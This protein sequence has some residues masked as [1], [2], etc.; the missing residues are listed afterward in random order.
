VI[1]RFCLLLSLGFAAAAPVVAEPRDGVERLRAQLI[2][3]GEAEAK[4]ER[5]VGDQRARLLALNAAQAELDARMAKNRGDM[6]KLLGAL[7]LYQRNPPPALVV[8]ARSAKDAVRAAILIRAVTPQLEQRRLA[9][10]AETNLLNKLRRDAAIASAALFESESAAAERRAHTDRL[11]ARKSALEASL[12]PPDPAEQAE[13]RAAAKGGLGALMSA[14]SNAPG[15][16]E[17]P[18]SVLPSRFVVPVQGPLVRRFGQAQRNGAQRNGALKIS[19]DH[20]HDHGLAWL[21]SPGA[22]V[23]SPAAG[24]IDYAGT[25]RGAR[26]QRGGGGAGGAHAPRGG[27]RGWT[28]SQRRR[29]TLSRGAARLGGHRPGP[30]VPRNV[31]FL[32]GRAALAS[33]PHNPY[34]NSDRSC[35]GPH[36]T[37]A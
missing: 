3:L 11:M 27:R 25:L 36:A 33:G 2:E 28:R 20:D 30:L 14:P 19:R 26:A 6:V 37:H 35:R 12:S 29:R 1:V 23:R 4:A 5:V 24:R 34:R 13:A 8:S 21:A 32:C 31:I 15:R 17:A 10:V 7:E 18:P 16:R 22:V 9:L